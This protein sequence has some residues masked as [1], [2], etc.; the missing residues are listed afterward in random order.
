MLSNLIFFSFQSIFI[1]LGFMTLF[2]LILSYFYDPGNEPIFLITFCLNIFI[3][4]L[5]NIFKNLKE[6]N[7]LRFMLGINYY[8]R[9]NTFI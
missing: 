7:N 9:S 4:F 1:S 6:I 2:T 3:I 8:N 5:I